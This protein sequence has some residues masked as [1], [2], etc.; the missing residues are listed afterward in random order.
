MYEKVFDAISNP[1]VKDYVPFSWVS[2][3]QVKREHYKA[4]ANYYVA[5]GLL[6]HEVRLNLVMVRLIMVLVIFNDVKML[7]LNQFEQQKH[8]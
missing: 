4:L 2:L 6:D 1:P 5:V 7:T 3:A 8:P